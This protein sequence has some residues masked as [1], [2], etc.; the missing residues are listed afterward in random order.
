MTDRADDRADGPLASRWRA[1]DRGWQAL[2]LGLAI[3][4]ASVAIGAV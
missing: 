3:V 4:A 2:L 1:L